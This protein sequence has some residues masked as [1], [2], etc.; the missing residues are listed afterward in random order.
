MKN[1]FLNFLK[2][3]FTFLFILM[4]TLSVGVTIAQPADTDLDEPDTPLDGGLSLLLAAGAALGGK[5]VY[6]MRK[7]KN[8]NND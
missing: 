5:K 7:K 2:K 4:F 6:D 8:S 1:R 3:P